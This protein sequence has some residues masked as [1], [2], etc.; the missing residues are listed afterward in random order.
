VRSYF[1]AAAVVAGLAALWVRVQLAWRRSFPE[2]TDDVDVLAARPGC[3][4]CHASFGC[5]SNCERPPLA[6][7]GRAKED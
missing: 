6:V 7:T 4:G 1:F 2:M 3:E 5:D